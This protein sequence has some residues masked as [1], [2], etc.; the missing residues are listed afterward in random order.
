MYS[1]R[2]VIQKSNYNGYGLRLVEEGRSER[3]KATGDRERWGAV[4][5]AGQICGGPVCARRVW[6][7]SVEQTYGATGR[8]THM[9]P[10]SL[11]RLASIARRDVEA[12]VFACE[13]LMSALRMLAQERA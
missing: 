12:Q 3:Y 6:L 9:A 13:M 5:V 2:Y 10:R 7:E 1:I 11:R 8:T 4:V